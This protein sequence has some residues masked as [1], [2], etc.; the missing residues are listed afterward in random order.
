[1][2]HSTVRPVVRSS[3]PLPTNRKALLSCATIALA[4]GIATPEQAKAQAA[5]GAFNGSISAATGA[6]QTS[7]GTGTETITVTG[8]TATINWSPTDTDGSGNVNFLPEGN[9]A[10]FQGGPSAGNFTVLNR[11]VPTDPNRA[12]ELNGKI[13]SYVDGGATGGN[14]WF[15]SPGGILVGANAVIDVGGLMLS[16]ANIFDGGWSANSDGFTAT[17]GSP[18]A[19]NAAINIA[20]GATIN[21]SASNA[22]LCRPGRSAHHAGGRRPRRRLG[23]V[24]RGRYG[25]PDSAAGAVRHPGRRR[26]NRE[27]FAQP[28]PQR[29]HYRPGQCRGQPFHLHDGDARQPGGHAPSGRHHRL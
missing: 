26:R 27:Q 24:C 25:D 16:T 20:A 11:I 29:K 19:I 2:T 14:I 23:G 17:A 6:S 10:T 3:R 8:P 9:V 13:Y 18:G 4:I 21:A 12:I 5:P 22:R 15:Y 1:M 28:G 7:L